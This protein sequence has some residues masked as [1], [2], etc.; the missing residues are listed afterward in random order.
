M[1]SSPI[2][3]KEPSALSV[4][5]TLTVPLGSGSPSPLTL[6]FSNSILFLAFRFF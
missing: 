6:V 2:N 5:K 1:E 4:L 3:S